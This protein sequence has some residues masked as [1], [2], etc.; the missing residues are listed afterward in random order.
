MK[1]RGAKAKCA[2]KGRTVL[3]N[4]NKIIKQKST[5]KKTFYPLANFIP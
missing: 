4:G 1:E 5:F 2:K 3:N